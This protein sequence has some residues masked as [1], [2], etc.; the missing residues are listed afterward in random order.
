MAKSKKA[1][2]VT[3]AERKLENEVVKN[4]RLNIRLKE[5][6][7]EKEAAMEGWKNADRVRSEFQDALD[8]LEARIQ[9]AL[10]FCDRAGFKADEAERMRYERDLAGKRTDGPCERDFLTRRIGS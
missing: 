7:K 4:R 5:A 2:L 1:L 9:A 6:L 3:T 8:N 10:A